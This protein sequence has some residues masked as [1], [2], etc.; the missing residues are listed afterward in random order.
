MT[1][2][3]TGPPGPGRSGRRPGAPRR[4]RGPRRAAPGGPRRPGARGPLGQAARGRA[5]GGV[6]GR[7]VQPAGDAVREAAE[8][9]ARE[10][11]PRRQVDADR[12]AAQ[13]VERPR[14]DRSVA[15]GGH[16]LVDQRPGVDPGVHRAAGSVK[17]RPRGVDDERARQRLGQCPLDLRPRRGGVQA[18]DRHAGDPDAG[19]DEVVPRVVVGRH[20][21]R[22]PAHEDEGGGER[23][24]RRRGA[25]PHMVACSAARR[26]KRRC[27][28]ALQAHRADRRAGGRHRARPGELARHRHGL[29]AVADLVEPGAARSASS[30]RGPGRCRCRPGAAGTR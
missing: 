9:P 15:A 5:D 21:H 17:R 13:A 2:G 23:D 10:V 22:A 28:L 26:R 19:G 25:S 14:E 20:G 30:R 7:A 16:G 27:R 6:D 1:F 29:A 12:L 3:R 8:R 11:R 24:R 4:R 18:P